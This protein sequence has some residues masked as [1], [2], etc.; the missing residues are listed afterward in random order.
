MVWPCLLP[1]SVARKHAC[2]KLSVHL[3]Q[4]PCRLSRGQLGGGGREEGWELSLG[5]E[6]IWRA[7]SLG[8]SQMSFLPPTGSPPFI[9]FCSHFKGVQEREGWQGV[10]VH[11]RRK[12]EQ[13]TTGLRRTKRMQTPR[14]DRDAKTQSSLLLPRHFGAQSKQ[15]WSKETICWFMKR[16]FIADSY[17]YYCNFF[18]FSIFFL[19][20]ACVKEKGSVEYK[21]QFPG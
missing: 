16:E 9:S 6:G 15:L 13:K 1:P 10:R 21:P 19:H 3:V 5:W 8:G 17:F 2:T 14:Q 11:R 20:W 7:W 18:S 12:W 4:A